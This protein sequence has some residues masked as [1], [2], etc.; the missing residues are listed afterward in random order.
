MVSLQKTILED[1]R[2]TIEN[3]DNIRHFGPELKDFSDTAALC[4]LMDIIVSVDTSVAHLAGTLGIPTYVLLPYKPDFRWM[5]NRK[6]SPWYP[7]MTLYR[8]GKDRSW[9]PVL[10]AIKSKLISAE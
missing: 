2:I 7:S 10:A 6:D 1:D 8:Q 5:L 3:L 4:K 9:F